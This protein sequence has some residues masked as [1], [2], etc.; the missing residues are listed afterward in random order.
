MSYN[1]TGLIFAGDIYMAT[2]ENDTPGDFMGPIN[3]TRLELT[4]P[5]TET[6]NRTSYQKDTFGQVL[7]SVNLP[8]DPPSLAMDFD[9][10]PATLLADTLAGKVESYDQATTSVTAEPATLSQDVWFKLPDQN[11]DPS[12]VTVTETSGSTQLEKDTDFEVRAEAGLIRATSEN[13]AT[14]VEID[15][16]TLQSS[17]QRILGGT[18]LSKAR[19]ILMDGTNLV[20]GRQATVT[21]HKT[22]F[23]ATQAMNLMS[24]EF[25]T[26]TLEGTMNTPTGKTSPFEIVM[27][28]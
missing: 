24:Q 28:E 5:Q 15:Y 20:T 4:P 22:T 16:D 9:S 21:I 11:I 19:K 26:G 8:G 12:T 17:G 6:V 7:D 1:D 3:T 2:I 14:D 18:E 25:I 27:P 10:L 13:G 23:S